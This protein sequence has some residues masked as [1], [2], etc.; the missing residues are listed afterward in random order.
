MSIK[1]TLDFKELVLLKKIS[2]LV[3]FYSVISELRSIQSRKQK[4]APKSCTKWVAF[5]VQSE[6]EQG[7]YIGKLY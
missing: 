4:G 7:N 3:G 6:Q 1:Y 5:I 2:D